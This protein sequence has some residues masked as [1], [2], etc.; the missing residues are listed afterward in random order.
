[1]C[2]TDRSTQLTIN[3]ADADMCHKGR[4]YRTWW[5][6]NAGGTDQRAKMCCDKIF[7]SARS[8]GLFCNILLFVNTTPILSARCI[9][10]IEFSTRSRQGTGP[11]WVLGSICCFPGVGQNFK[12]RHCA[13]RHSVFHFHCELKLKVGHCRQARGIVDY[14]VTQAPTCCKSCCCWQTSRDAC[15]WAFYTHRTHLL[16]ASSRLH[17]NVDH[18]TSDVIVDGSPV[19]RQVHIAHSWP[20][21][22]TLLQTTLHFKTYTAN[23]D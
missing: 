18:T 4:N 12:F 1:M 23:N 19:C 10:S 7:F 13:V 20:K 5:P 9:F 2:Q 14:R 11:Y 22:L 6:G 21:C 16:I 8:S 15:V 3:F 17:K